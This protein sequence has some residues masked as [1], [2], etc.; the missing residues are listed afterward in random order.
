VDIYKNHLNTAP[1]AML[2]TA[3]KVSKNKYN[4]ENVRK[5][6]AKVGKLFTTK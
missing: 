5:T 3:I 1:K 6:N 4:V 2:I